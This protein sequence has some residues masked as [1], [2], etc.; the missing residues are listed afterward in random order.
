[1]GR[2]LGALAAAAAQEKPGLTFPRYALSGRSFS[3]I[4]DFDD[5]EQMKKL[6]AY[7]GG[8]KTIGPAQG[9]PFRVNLL[10]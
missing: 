3:A 10:C 5:A 7:L 2:A 1:M 4:Y 9:Q 8:W 6:G